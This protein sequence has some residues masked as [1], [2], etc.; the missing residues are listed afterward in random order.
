[1]LWFWPSAAGQLHFPGHSKEESQAQT[2]PLHQA[3]S[4]ASLDGEGL[5]EER[6]TN[7]SQHSSP[8]AGNKGA[9]GSQ[10]FLQDVVAQRVFTPWAGS[11]NK[12]QTQQLSPALPWA[13]E[14]QQE[15]QD[16]HRKQWWQHEQRVRWCTRHARRQRDPD[17]GGRHGPAPASSC[18]WSRDRT[19]RFQQ[20]GPLIC[21][22]HSHPWGTRTHQPRGTWA[23]NKAGARRLQKVQSYMCSLTLQVSAK[24][25]SC[26]LGNVPLLPSLST[27]PASR[28]KSQHCACHSWSST[29]SKG[30]G[31]DMEPCQGEWDRAPVSVWAQLDKAVSGERAVPV[32]H[33]PL[34]PSAPQL[35]EPCL[36][37]DSLFGYVSP[38]NSQFL[39]GKSSHVRTELALVVPR[40]RDSKHSSKV[41]Q[42]FL[43]VWH[44][45]ATDERYFPRSG[46]VM[47]KQCAEQACQLFSHLKNLRYR[48]EP[49]FVSLWRYFFAKV[50]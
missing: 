42:H 5:H 31:R 16:R 39:L 27:S 13:D 15:M 37:R 14:M 7:C 48:I 9:R 43:S 23:A 6:V 11:T 8:V 17:T 45:K 1:M 24:G 22:Q 50:V 34:L 10:Q 28:N 19:S 35:Q 12:Q 49:N 30:W 18:C 20:Q 4:A 21:Q 38:S 25:N 41:L 3:P 44:S 40:K 33:C 29:G 47:S 32:L 26:T 46:S 36:P 2:A